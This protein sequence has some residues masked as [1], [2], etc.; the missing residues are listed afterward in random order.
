[1]KYLFYALTF[2]MVL[3]CAKDTPDDVN[4]VSVVCEN[5]PLKFSIDVNGISMNADSAWLVFHEDPE[6]VGL[7]E[8]FPA[9]LKWEYPG[10]P[11]W[12][13]ANSL[14]F[15]Y[16]TS[17]L[18]S[19]T[20]YEAREVLGVVQFDGS[21]GEMFQGLGGESVS[22][23][24]DEYNSDSGYICGSFTGKALF[25]DYEVVE[26]EGSFKGVLNP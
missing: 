5:D 4:A 2:F 1:M 8:E 26:L 21:S 16:N 11:E 25:T 12:N 3:G 23:T 9:V 22:V 15:I 20:T 19:S 14:T 6:S 13:G 10:Y 7:Q 24:V 18:E 17:K